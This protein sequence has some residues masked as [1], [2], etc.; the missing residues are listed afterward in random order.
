MTDEW[1]GGVNDFCLYCNC[2]GAVMETECLETL[3]SQMKRRINVTNVC[4]VLQDAHDTVI[5]LY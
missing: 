3:T 4:I 5:K 2:T 1:N